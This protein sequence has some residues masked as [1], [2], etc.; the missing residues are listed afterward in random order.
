MKNINYCIIGAG[1][2]GKNHI[3]TANEMGILAG[4]IESNQ[5]IQEQLKE[6]YPNATI[7]SSLNDD[8]A[9]DYDAYSVV[10]PAE[11]HYSVAKKLIENKKACL[12]RKANHN[13]Q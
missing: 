7:H 8:G 10:V 1:R 3:R 11:H 6:E 12:N 2:W 13:K 4:I 9:M 5:D